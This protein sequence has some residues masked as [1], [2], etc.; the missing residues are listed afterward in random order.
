MSD[1]QEDMRWMRRALRLAARGYTPPNPMVGCVLV[2]DGAVVGEGYHL[3]AGGPHAEVVALEAAGERARG[4]TAYVSLEPCSHS[5]RTPPCAPAL[6]AAGVAR[7]VAAALDPNPRVSGKGIAILQEAGIAVQ[8]GLLEE[9]ARRLNAAFF[10]YQTTGRPFVLLKA[11]MTLDGK[12]ATRT[13]DSRWITGPRARRHVH[14]L[15]AQSGAVLCGIG[16]A[17]ADDPLL[18]ARLPGV[19]RQPLRVV[20]DTHLRL[21]LTSR[22]VATA[23][24]VPTLIAAGKTPDRCRRM[25]LE[26]CGIEV[27]CLP[28]N[29]A[30]RIALPELLAELGRR[31]VISV[32]VE[33]GSQINAAFLEGGHVHRLLWFIAPKLI[34]GRDAPT[35]V[36]GTGAALMADAVSLSP[37]RVRRF[38]PDLLLESAPLC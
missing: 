7:V 16:T 37:F 36:A 21:P 28:T 30:G 19:P 25:A 4:A 38:G 17:L 14:R 34:G 8:V 5:G 15:R 26:N 18:T 3:R 6:V 27:I 1:L 10:H 31:E 11:A 9:E 32:L 35:P 29:A 33:G 12:I 20:L 2:K 24:E 23:R 13:G 22:L